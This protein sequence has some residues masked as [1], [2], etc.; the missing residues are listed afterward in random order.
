[1]NKE[2]IAEIN[3]IRDS[4]QA[5]SYMISSL[6]RMKK[7][8]PYIEAQLKN[9]DM[10]NN[11]LA[12]PLVESGYNADE[13]SAML[14]TG[15]WQFIPST[16]KR[17]DL[18]VNS[19]RDD[20]L[21]TQLSTQAALSYLKTL[22]SQFHDWKLAVIAYEIGEKN[23]EQLIHATGSRDPWVLAQSPSAPKELKK[24]IP[25]FD[26]SVIIMN[27]PELVTKQN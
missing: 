6:D 18:T 8:K 21:D 20:R 3:N 7:Y 15:I 2:V 10:P 16:A 4:K 22:H 9:N 1:M 23:T 25:M 11:L 19:Q 17:F 5:R 12:L 26:A 13:K 27:N 24:F 14:A